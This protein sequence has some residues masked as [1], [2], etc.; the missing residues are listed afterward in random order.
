MIQGLR[1]DGQCRVTGALRSGTEWSI[2][3]PRWTQDRS[4][5]S[6]FVRMTSLFVVKS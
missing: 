2:S 3:R 6:F 4:Q 5:G 1:E